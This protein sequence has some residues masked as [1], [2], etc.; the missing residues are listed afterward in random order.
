MHTDCI[1]FPF[2]PEKTYMLRM[3]QNS[4][5]STEVKLRLANHRQSFRNIAYR[6]A[7][8]LSQYI[9]D[10]KEKNAE[11]DIKW[12]IRSN[13]KPAKL[14]SRTCN[15]CST[16]KLEIMRS[17][18]KTTLNSRTELGNKCRHRAKFK[19][20]HLWPFELQ[21]VNEYPLISIVIPTN[22]YTH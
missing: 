8:K 19:L 11:F 20:K 4:S 1:F 13:A 12:S 15:L 5:T 3:C 14:G 17:D 18:P 22:F 10:L 21:Q 2:G 7:T 9:W 6:D 16:E